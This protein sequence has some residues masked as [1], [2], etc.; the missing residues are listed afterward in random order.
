MLAG[1]N[2]PYSQAA[3]FL[4]IYCRGARYLPSWLFRLCFTSWVGSVLLHMVNSR[5]SG[6]ATAGDGGSYSRLLDPRTNETAQSL[7][8]KLWSDYSFGVTHK[9]IDERPLNEIG[10]SSFT[11]LLSDQVTESYGPVFIGHSLNTIFH[12]AK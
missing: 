7:L 9:M 12:I 10:T 3:W 6:P 1:C 2:E 5:V 4:A 8:I 11:Q